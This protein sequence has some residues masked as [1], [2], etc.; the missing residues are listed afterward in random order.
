MA[1]RPGQASFCEDAR[2]GGNW[3]AGAASYSRSMTPNEETDLADRILGIGTSALV[4]PDSEMGR[5]WLPCR[6]TAAELARG[7][8]LPPVT[9][10]EASIAANV[11]AVL[12][13]YRGRQ[14]P[15]PESWR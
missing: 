1:W 12:G 4:I 6:R 3:A 8:G 14:A 13:G 2:R 5:N 15:Q 9:H 10:A 7:T 11:S